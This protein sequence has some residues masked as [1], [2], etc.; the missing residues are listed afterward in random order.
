[1]ADADR[2]HRT[3]V[4]YIDKSREYYLERGFGNPYRWSHF[5]EAPFV[6]LS[7]PLSESRVGLVTTA[8]PWPEDGAV[9]APVEGAAKHDGKRVYSMPLSPPPARLYTDDLSWDKEATHT[10]DLDSFLPIRRLLEAEQSG[11]IGSAAPRFHGVPTSFSQ[12]QTLERDA[13]EILSRLREDGSEVALLSP[14]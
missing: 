14:L 4:S 6:R 3:F 7:K 10:E 9:V 2:T 5:D 13:P 1:M 12:R 11:R 8:T